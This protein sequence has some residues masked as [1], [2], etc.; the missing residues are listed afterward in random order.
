[1]NWK[2]IFW[3]SWVVL[4]ISNIFLILCIGYMVEE[5]DFS[6]SNKEISNLSLCYNMS[7]IDTST[8]LN[9]FVRNIFIYNDTDD[10]LELSLLD[11]ISRGG[12]CGDWS[13]FYISNFNERGF[14]TKRE[15]IFIEKRNETNNYHVY[16]LAY[17]GSGYCNL[18]MEN[19]DCVEYEI[20]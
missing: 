5:E 16:V 1:M 12:D 9:K 15:R 8:C 14:K 2:I 7:L 17:D 4:F 20:D 11:L 6:I 13:D 18:D 3:I 19:V 10:D